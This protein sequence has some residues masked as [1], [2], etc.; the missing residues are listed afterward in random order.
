MG[1][2]KRE[3]KLY[4]TERERR[5]KNFAAQKILQIL[6]ISVSRQCRGPTLHMNHPRKTRTRRALT[7]QPGSHTYCTFIRP[8]NIPIRLSPLQ[9]PSHHAKPCQKITYTLRQDPQTRRRQRARRLMARARHGYG[10]S[11]GCL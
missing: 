5:R 8:L 11:Q 9:H 2:G 7:M 3:I 4:S 10:C 1:A 6:A